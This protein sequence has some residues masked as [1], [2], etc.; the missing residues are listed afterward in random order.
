MIIVR[1]WE[2]LG[3]QM[4]QYAYARALAKERQDV[5][6]D[7][8]KAYDD[9][10]PR[11]LTAAR[12]ETTVDHFRITLPSVDVE[13]LGRYSYLRRKNG[14][15]Y[16]IAEMAQKKMWP[17][18]FIETKVPDEIP[19]I[20]KWN[21][22][23]YIKGWF[24]NENVFAGIRRE[25]LREFSPKEKIRIPKMLMG[26]IFEK[27]SVAVQIRR[28]DYVTTHIVLPVTYYKR[29]KTEIEKR[30]Q[31]PIYIVFSDD[32]KWAKE[33]VDLGENVVYV[34]EVT[35]WKDYEQLYVMSRCKN[36]I[37]A[38][39]TFSWWAAWLNQNQDKVIV[40]PKQYVMSASNLRIK[41]SIVI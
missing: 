38:N 5:Y 21:R 37:I 24:Q 32:Y 19:L 22:N 27:E 6:L 17:F 33:H 10:F 8:G 20:H 1:I 4:F 40:M 36:Q 11:L 29:A 31:D 26:K 34:D 13:K 3:N 7:L 9:F 14:V 15:E 41:N 12:R 28:G 30:V 35:D 2:G 18:A 23:C 16:L 39:S 25:L